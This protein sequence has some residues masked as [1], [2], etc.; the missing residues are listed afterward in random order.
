MLLALVACSPSFPNAEQQR[1][2]GAYETELALCTE[3]SDSGPAD[4]ACMCGVAKRFG[5][6]SAEFCK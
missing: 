5:R 2:V 6:P 4:D 1:G 3:Q